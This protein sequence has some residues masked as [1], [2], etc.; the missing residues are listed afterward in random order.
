[1]TLVILGCVIIAS[2]LNVGNAT[3]P[4]YVQA[5]LMRMVVNA[6]IAVYS[7]AVMIATRL[8]VLRSCNVAISAVNIAVMIV[9]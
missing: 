1:M 4:K 5:V 7:T 9:D 3:P 2:A 8:T 6:L